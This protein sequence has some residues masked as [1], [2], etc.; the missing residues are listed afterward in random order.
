MNNDSGNTITQ[1]QKKVNSRA[2]KKQQ[3]HNYL[4]WFFRDDSTPKVFVIPD[5]L[6]RLTGRLDAALFLSQIMYWEDKGG[7]EDG[8]FY[9]SK[10]QWEQET[11]IPDST[12]R[13]LERIFISE[14]W[15]ETKL[16]KAHGK[17]TVHYRVNHSVLVSAIYDKCDAEGLMVSKEL[18]TKKMKA[19]KAQ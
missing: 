3:I 2:D 11:L 6:I 9:K 15:I 10:K 16:I 4:T 17:P 13:K 7:R 19:S 18:G 14:G 12:L 1:E 5:Y 8:Y